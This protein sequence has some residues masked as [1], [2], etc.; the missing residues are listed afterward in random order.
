MNADGSGLY[1]LSAPADGQ[2]LSPDWSPDGRRIVFYNHLSYNIWSIFV[3]NAD[4]SNVQQLTTSRTRDENPNWSPDGSQIA[5]CRDGDIWVMQ[6]SDDPVL[7]VSNLRPLTST[8]DR[9]ENVPAWSPDGTQIAFASILGG[10]NADDPNLDLTTMEIYVM[11]ADGT[12]IRQLTDNNFV[13]DAPAWS[14]DGTRIAFY[15]DRTGRNQIYVMDSDGRNLQRLTDNNANDASP[16]WSP[17]GTKI[18]FNSDRDGN[19]E[20]YVMNIDGSNQVRLTNTTMDK[21]GPFWEPAITAP[22]RG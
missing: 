22:S 21:W 8:P 16:A 1:A 7:Q 17:N 3:A 15:S 2:W 20:I 13:D 11:N 19:Y 10:S 12:N 14:P 4:G 6:V 5:F 18:A 9:Y